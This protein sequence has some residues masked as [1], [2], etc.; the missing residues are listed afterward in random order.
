MTDRLK[1]SVIGNTGVGKTS[2][3]QRFIYNSSYVST[4]TLGVDYFT[5]KHNYRGLLTS[6]D[7][8]L[9]KFSIWDLSGREAFKKI[10]IP[11]LSSA[12][13]LILVFDLNNP[14]S[15]TK[16]DDWFNDA[17]LHFSF[18]FGKNH[19]P[20]V[21]IGNKSDLLPH[22]VSSDKAQEWSLKHGFK[23]FE[24]SAKTDSGVRTAIN[25]FFNTMV[26]TYHSQIPRDVIND[27]AISSDMPLTTSKYTNCTI[28]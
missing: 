9:I 28:L 26:E 15:F 17:K 4:P 22:L 5:Y 20:G 11:Y 19:I 2:I 12:Q 18:G 14:E 1:V 13:G 6:L 21:V 10:T 27:S 3:L 16:L 7:N 24:V 25:D 8:T 23:Y